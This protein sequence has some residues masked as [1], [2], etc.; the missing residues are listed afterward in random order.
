MAGDATKSFL[1]RH[2]WQVIVALLA[3]GGAWRGL[4]VT[5]AGKAD[6]YELEALSSRVDDIAPV[7]Q[8]VAA[9][10]SL[11]REMIQEQREINAEIR[12]VRALICRSD[13]I[14]SYCTRRP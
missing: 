6:R 13:L 9:T 2:G 5:V 12:T 4:D 11:L 8:R 3:L 7:A 14:D 1:E 10:D